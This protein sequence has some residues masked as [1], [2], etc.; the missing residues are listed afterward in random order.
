M[1]SEELG[2]DHFQIYS[3]PNIR[4]R[5]PLKVQGL[6]DR[7]SVDGELLFLE[8]F[9][10][11]VVKNGERLHDKNAH[12]NVYYLYGSNKDRMWMVR[13][14]NQFGRYTLGPIF[15]SML[16]AVPGKCLGWEELSDVG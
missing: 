8:G 12:F 1:K 10:N 15:A 6:F 2:L 9:A 7:G 14:E 13:P 3:V 5:R 16:L 4:V 11:P